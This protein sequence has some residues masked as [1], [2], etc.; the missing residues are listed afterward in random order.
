MVMPKLVLPKETKM[1]NGI[2]LYTLES[3][4]KDV[5]RFDMLFSGGYGVQ[6]KPLQ[7]LFTNRM[8]R[9][10]AGRL[11]S[12]EISR[13]FDNYGAW[14]DMYSSQNCNHITLYTLAKHFE[15]MLDVLCTM[16]MN[17]QFSSK[18]L[19]TVRRNNK[20]Y[21]LINSRKVEVLAQRHFENSL[22]GYEHPLGHIICA[23]DYDA[24]TR[25]NLLDYHQ[26]VYNSQNCTMFMAGNVS[27]NMLKAVATRLGNSCWG[28]GTGIILSD[29]PQHS[30]ALGRKTVCVEKALQSAVK[31]G[32]MS[33]DA[34]HAD[35]FPLRFL[36]I[37]F[38]GYFGSRLMSNIRER[39]GYTYHIQA[40]LDAYGKKNA[41]MI[42]TETTNDHVEPLIDEVYK[43]MHRLCC[44]TITNQELELVR[45]YTF[46]EL[47]REYEGTLA[48]SEVFI[49]AWLSGEPFDTVNRYMEYIKNVNAEELQRV[50]CKYLQRDKMFEVVVGA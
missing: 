43:E 22:W 37:L 5:V 46:G 33:V 9:E 42:T 17:P 40:E 4:V 16:V 10:G 36:T 48:K 19:E 25:E 21:F 32:C 1:T 26:Q 38:G 3:N 2:S 47:C 7:A 15:P 20:S 23:E 41:F 50:A 13:K 30:S 14:I 18:N 6:Q 29:I 49:N 8:L 44:E 11:S 24:I 27:D 12:A 39:N 31:I 28:S 35:M 45:N 34:S